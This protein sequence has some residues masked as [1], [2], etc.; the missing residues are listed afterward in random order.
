MA[1]LTVTSAASA[2]ALTDRYIKFTA[3]TNPST[4]GISVPTKA[5]IDGEVVYVTDATLSP[6]CL[7]SRGMEGTAAT[8]HNSLAP[9]VYGLTSDF[10]QPISTNGQAQANVLSYS[11]NNTS[12]T[13][14]VVNSTIYITKAG[15]LAITINGP[16]NDQSNTIK[17]VSLTA[18]AHTITYTAGFYGNTTSSDVCTFPSTIG[19]VFTI[20][21]K[22]GLWNAESNVSSAG[23]TLG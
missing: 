21:A 19:A 12:V 18:N 23:V 10:T 15:V 14:P 6:T 9:I 3:F 8:A 4:G 17:F 20:T 22:N 13:L 2:V 1:G 7:V 11:V 5:I 16:N